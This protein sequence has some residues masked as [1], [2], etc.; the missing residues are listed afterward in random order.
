MHGTNDFQVRCT[1]DFE[2]CA[3]RNDPLLTTHGCTAIGNVVRGFTSP[4]RRNFKKERSSWERGKFAQEFCE[5][6]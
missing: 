2:T 1:A 5:Q 6:L 4:D 3:N